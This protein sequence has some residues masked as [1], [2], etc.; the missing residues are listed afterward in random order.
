MVLID[1]ILIIAF[2]IGT[3]KGLKNG[4]FV[5][6]SSFIGLLVGLWVALKFSDVTRDFLGEHLGSNPKYSYFFAFIITFIAVVVG[7]SILAKVLTKIAD[8]SGIGILNNIGGALFGFARSLLIMSVLLNIFDKVNFTNIL[9]S[10][11]SLEKSILY[12]PVK[13]IGHVVYP[14][15]STELHDIKIQLPN[16][17]E[18]PK[19]E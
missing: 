13:A 12:R 6:F 2:F 1:I 9:A 10:Q 14:F 16:P 4:L 18:K 3:F 5:E 17:E 7:I 11:E 15:L 8:F 19:P